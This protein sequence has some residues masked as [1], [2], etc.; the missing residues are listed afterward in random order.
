MK[1]IRF[2]IN[3]FIVYNSA[4]LRRGFAFSSSIKN[5]PL[6]KSRNIQSQSS[7]STNASI[8]IISSAQPII[9][10]TQPIDKSIQTTLL[11]HT[12]IMGPKQL[13]VQQSTNETIDTSISDQ[14]FKSKTDSNV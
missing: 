14:N 6:L 4:I 10:A 12:S 13:T 8:S 3:I 7:I 1:I 5:P 9:T 11:Q 2:C